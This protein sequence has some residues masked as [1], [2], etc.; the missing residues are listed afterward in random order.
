[1][2]R[3]DFFRTEK[4]NR[5]M[6]IGTIRWRTATVFL[7]IL[8]LG[9][10]G[11]RDS[12]RSEGGDGPA[13]I[14]PLATAETRALYAKLRSLSERQILFG[15]H[16]A[17]AYGHSW[18]GERGRSDV[19]DVCGSHPAVFGHDFISITRSDSPEV[20]KRNEDEL[21]VRIQ[22]VRRCNGV[23]TIT[24]HFCNPADSGSFYWPESPYASLPELLPGGKL[25]ERYRE[26]LTT[27]ARFA[28]SCKADDGKLIPMLFRPF[29]EY[30]GDWFWWGVPA[31]ATAEEFKAVWRY[32][33]E[34][35]RDTLQVHNFIYV[36]SPDCRF[37]TK[38][39]YLSCYPG[40]EYVDMVG[41]DDYW[42]LRP[43]GGSEAD[44]LKK[45]TILSEVAEEHRKLAALTET[46]V[47]GI[48]DPDW[49][50]GTLLRLLQT[51]NFRLS[52]AMVWRNACDSP[53]H[54]YAPF[55]GHPSCADFVR[56]R[57]DPYTLFADDL[58]PMYRP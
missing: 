27:I 11:D 31:H 33:V 45:L 50:T 56:F 34:Y 36:I 48:P 7:T 42:D 19:K 47:E 12:S 46:G 15:H 51:R 35:L 8:L 18:E 22:E 43:D 13:L 2:F 53:T 54:Y 52:Y 16:D 14:D 39:E 17:N 21:R 41:M 10:C 3:P 4:E 58:P 5:A 30:D 28:V 40:D 29:H 23:N 32:T 6:N 38:E 1:M 55:P 49:W 37:D 20:Q 44:F 24:W 57:N 25:H 26:I 9:A